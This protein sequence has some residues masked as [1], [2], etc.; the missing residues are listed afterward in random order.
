MKELLVLARDRIG[1]L[2]DLA[3]MLG[4]ANINIESIS[5]D[6]LGDKAVMHIIVSDDKLG[7]DILEK[8]GFIVMSSDAI[9]I[10]IMDRPGELAKVARMLADAKINIKNVQ[11]LTKENKL[12]LYTLRV[13]NVKKASTLLKDYM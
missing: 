13:D 5:A 8:G 9:V 4:Q 7:K 6:T 1:L 10:K 3:Y 2:A 11:L 12:A